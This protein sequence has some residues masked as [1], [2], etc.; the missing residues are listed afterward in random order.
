MNNNEVK[1]KDYIVNAENAFLPQGWW[2]NFC[3]T[4]GVFEPNCEIAAGYYLKAALQYK[5]LKKYD[6]ASKCFYKVYELQVQS[7]ECKRIA[8][9]YLINAAECILSLDK[10]KAITYYQL[11]VNCLIDNFEFEQAGKRSM[12]LADI[13]TQ[14]STYKDA[15]KYYNLA[16][17]YFSVCEFRTNDSLKCMSKI[18]ELSVKSDDIQVAVETFEALALHYK[19]DQY[20]KHRYS[21]YCLDTMICRLT[22]GDLVACKKSLNYYILLQPSLGLGEQCKFIDNLILAMDQYDSESFCK[23]IDDRT[24]K[25]KDWH[26]DFLKKIEERLENDEEDDLR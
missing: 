25:L 8:V 5:L 11:A 26:L 1:A 12:I 3:A 10:T 22:I 15:I 16:I 20:L 6:K 21:E 4:I 19:D 7:G 18:A 9:G 17:K 13:Y 23:I 14:D 2:Q 24:I